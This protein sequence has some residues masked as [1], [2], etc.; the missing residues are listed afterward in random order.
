MNGGEQ[1][2]QFKEEFDR[3]NDSVGEE[4]S[5]EAIFKTLSSR[6]RRYA[7]QYLAQVEGPV[8][9]RD[10]SE[11]VTAWEN[12]I[13]RQAV[14]P[15]Q[16]K[17]VYTALHQT[18]LPKMDHL[19]VAVYNRDRGT[20]EITDHVREFDIYLDVVPRGDIPWSQLYLVLGSVLSALVIVAALGFPPFSA[21][22]G[23]GYAMFVA[24]TFTV[25]GAAHVLYDRRTRIETN[26][27]SADIQP[28]QEVSEVK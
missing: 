9:I 17:R 12:G 10:L 20:V 24:V 5:T 7:L 23:F 4:L 1:L 8:T 14:T 26:T 27:T 2:L 22:G 28:P 13:D 25:A 11:Q 6:R 16:R 15:K 21:V 19:G 3:E 18:H